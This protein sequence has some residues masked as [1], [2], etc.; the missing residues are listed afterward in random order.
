MS[1]NKKLK[2]AVHKK[3][4]QGIVS[5]EKNLVKE[6]SAM[7]GISRQSVHRYIAKMIEDKT[8]E[9]QV[10][11]KKRKYKLVSVER[12]EHL[13]TKGLQ[14]DVVWAE[15]VSGVLR[16]VEKNIIDICYYGFT[17]MLNNAID[18][19]ESEDVIVT[20]ERNALFVELYVKDHGVGI[21]N[22]IQ[23]ECNLQ[24]PQHA[25]LELAKG[26]YTS[27]P[28]RHTGQ[29][30]FFTSRMF[31]SFSIV[32]GGLI[33][34]SGSSG[35]DWLWELEA[36]SEGT[37]V[38][39]RIAIDSKATSVE[40]FNKYASPDEDDFGFAKTIVPV[41]LLDHEGGILVSRSQAKR[42][43]VRFERFR[44]VVLD[45]KGIESIGQAFA[46]ELFRVFQNQHPEV[47]LIPWNDQ[48]GVSRMIKMVKDTK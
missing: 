7:A 12:I 21:F 15:V 40:V 20:V 44:E 11:G 23:R 16:G 41:R 1:L 17:E 27:D 33:F 2:E 47:H 25:I 18:H 10:E 3:L 22:K 36:A 42:L 5:G 24:L 6:V 13:K 46:D 39:M 28:S 26:K 35:Q 34:S 19:S 48:P 32:S 29:G 30:I 4:L 31:D 14:E 8:I 43:T 37:A 9:V 45:F 38:F